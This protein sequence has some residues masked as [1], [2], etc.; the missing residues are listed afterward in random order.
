MCINVHFD[1]TIFNWV[2]H[3]KQTLA[4]LEYLQKDRT[5][6]EIQNIYVTSS[7]ALMALIPN[8]INFRTYIVDLHPKAGYKKFRKITGFLIRTLWHTIGKPV[9]FLNF[10]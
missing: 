1:G 8:N 3:R 4:F 7:D 2:P 6:Y 5:K 9:I 10:L